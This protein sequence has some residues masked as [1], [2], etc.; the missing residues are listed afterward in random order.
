VETSV[1]MELDWIC[2]KEPTFFAVLT[3]VYPNDT[4]VMWKEGVV[5]MEVYVMLSF[6][7]VAAKDA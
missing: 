6:S 5:C 3:E 4:V 2:L 7:V 1:N